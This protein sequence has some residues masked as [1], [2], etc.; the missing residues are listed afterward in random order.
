MRFVI[1]SFAVPAFWLATTTALAQVEVTIRDRRPRPGYGFAGTPNA[2][3][4]AQ[5]ATPSAAAEERPQRRQWLADFQLSYG[6]GSWIRTNDLQY[7]KLPRYQAALYP[8]LA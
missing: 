3:S 2:T 8:D 1:A 6:R 4:T 5:V 7:P